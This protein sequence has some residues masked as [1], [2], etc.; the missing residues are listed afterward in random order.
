MLHKFGKLKYF[1]TT[2]IIEIIMH[3]FFCFHDDNENEVVAAHIP[4]H[5]DSK[6]KKPQ[7]QDSKTKKLWYWDLGTKTLYI[8]KHRQINHIIMIP[9]RFFRGRKATI[10]RL[11]NHNIEIP[12]PKN[13]DIKLLWNSDPHVPWW[14]MLILI[15]AFSDLTRHVE[16]MGIRCFLVALAA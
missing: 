10:S 8:E 7:H 3:D 6:N 9:K 12:R 2:Y 13:Q 5:R 11:K 15:L 1:S 16:D 4:Q 14:L